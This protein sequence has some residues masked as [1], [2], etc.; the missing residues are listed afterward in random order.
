MVFVGLGQGVEAAAPV[1][2]AFSDK[3]GAEVFANPD[4]SGQWCGENVSLSLLLRDDSPL[5]GSGLSDFVGRVGG[6]LPPKC[7]DAKRA[8]VAVYR[9][10]DRKL[11]SGPYTI[12]KAE[13][14][15]APV[16]AVTAQPP[17]GVAS[18]PQPQ[19]ETKAEAPA[20]A[21]APAAVYTPSDINP[22]NAVLLTKVAQNPALLNDNGVLRY[23]ARL[24]MPGD[25]NPVEN[26][27]FKL[28]AV[29][30][31][32]REDL[33]EQVARS[34]GGKV[35]FVVSA[36]LGAYDFAH[37]AFPIAGLGETV[38][39]GKPV[40]TVPSMDVLGNSVQFALPDLPAIDSLPM[41]PKEA[42][43]YIARH[44]RWGAIDRGIAIAVAVSYKPGT[45]T[46]E[47]GIAKISAHI[48]TAWILDGNRPIHTY[49]SAQLAELQH[50]HE[51][52]QEAERQQREEQ[53]RTLR[54]AAFSQQR[55]QNATVLSR[56]PADVR[57][58]NFLSNVPAVES[59]VR[60][61]NL[62]VAR[63][64]ALTTQQPVAVRMLVQAESGGSDHV[65]TRW[66]G[67]LRVTVKGVPALERGSWYLVEGTLTLDGPAE[68]LKPAD[69][70]AKTVFA[71]KQDLCADAQDPGAIMDRKI[72][73]LSHL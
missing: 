18:Q 41:E 27:E 43:A 42:E 38:N 63:G 54:L 59:G 2:I 51:A 56:L 23:W 62:A 20:P 67:H 10:S 16:P 26:Q 36:R 1:Q 47:Y 15:A 46:V 48:D 40:W 13:N 64:R 37:S 30:A 21:P 52:R 25:Y 24:R 60:L 49:E 66:P 32:A 9:T 44:T 72:A 8:R 6:M 7:A 61:D 31:K 34:T 68:E 19:P 45:E 39:F 22:F 57:L 58:A 28:P 5:I 69:L 4:A 55:E 73:A 70:T 12:A 35:T 50:Q 3:L 33:Q 29:L 11:V 65:D 14:W 53:E 17:Q 71:C